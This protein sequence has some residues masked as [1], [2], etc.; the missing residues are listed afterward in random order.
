MAERKRRKTRRALKN[1]KQIKKTMKKKGGLF[2][3]KLFVMK[4]KQVEDE[5]TNV[6]VRDVD[7]R[8]KYKRE[9]LPGLNDVVEVPKPS[10][11]KPGRERQYYKPKRKFVGDIIS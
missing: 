7:G 10:P 6:G 9:S 8:D 5:P 3:M 11:P 2:G 1:G 4:K